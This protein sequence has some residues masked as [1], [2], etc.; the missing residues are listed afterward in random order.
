MSASE[1]SEH[2][3]LRRHHRRSL[4]AAY[5]EVQVRRAGRKRYSLRGH[6]YDISAGGMLFELDKPLAAGERVEVRV[7]LPGEPSIGA[8]GSVVR[9]HDP[10]IPGPIRMALTFTHIHDHDRLDACLAA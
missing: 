7:N 1:S 2:P 4:P 8:A 6:A 3:N 5:T 9:F 10:N